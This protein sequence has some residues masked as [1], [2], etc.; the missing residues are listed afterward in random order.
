MKFYLDGEP[1]GTRT[2][3]FSYFGHGTRRWGFVGDGSEAGSENAG[4]NSIYY[5]GDISQLF[6]LSAS[7]TD[8][9]VK[10]HWLKTKFRYGL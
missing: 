1:D 8:A 2:N 3:S 6:L 9:Q 4:R 10:Q 5:E 7:W